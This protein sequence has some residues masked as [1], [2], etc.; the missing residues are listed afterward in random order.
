MKKI[1]LF[2]SLFVSILSA[3]AFADTAPVPTSE[4][5]PRHEGWSFSDFRAIPIQS[6]G[7]IKPLDSFAREAALFATGRRQFEGFDPADLLI[8]WIAFPR[9]WEN[10]RFVKI[11]RIDVRRE[12]QLDESR[13][14]FSP[15]E[16][17]NNFALLQYARNMDA[18]AAGSETMSG[19][20]DRGRK[21][22]PREQE[23]GNVLSRLTLFRD[24]VAGNAWLVIPHADGPWVSLAGGGASAQPPAPAEDE[25]IRAHF[26]DLIKAYQAGDMAAFDRASSVARAAVESRVPDW[27]GHM[28]RSL[29]LE[30]FYNR[31]HPFQFAWILYLAGALMWLVSPG[32]LLRLS[33]EQAS[34]ARVRRVLAGTLTSLAVIC[35]V[36]GFLIRCYIAGRPPVTNMYE[37]II[38]V[39]FGVF[40]FAFI[41]YLI[42]RLSITLIVAS[43]L[44][45]V[46]LIAA[47][48]APAMMDPGLHP[49][50]PVL[51]DNFWLTIHVLTIT[52]G[53]SAFALTLGLANVTLWNFFMIDRAGADA[54]DAPVARARI[55][56]LNQLTYRAMQFGVVL[57]AA[58]TILG[59][60]WA[61]YSWGRFWGWD[62]KEVWALIA[63]LCYLAVLHGRMT[64]WIKPFAFA[65]WTVVAFSSVV[66]AWY[67]VNFVL[68]VGL[69][70]Y[71]FASGGTGYV[72]GG[73]GLQLAYVLVIALHHIWTSKMAMVAPKSAV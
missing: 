51:R 2:L 32:K 1:L 15:S 62:P 9:E 5:A 54:S 53:Y 73:V 38:W 20:S 4:M 52:L 49:L 64:S 12:L 41:L 14:Y 42:Q 70:S 19:K 8:S 31:M 48:S 21:E 25:A 17:F 72:V 3:S 66:M 65:V 58:G 28:A 39:S 34:S 6:G 46:G 35:H 67:G 43:A 50:V 55:Q 45:T 40:A 27:D 71:G 18:S 44:S 10:H 36:G 63:L 30:V 11:S 60:V 61:D 68:G 56:T 7:R 59:G 23:L 22:S 37:S 24:I 26:V 69:H 29:G 47:D 57:L 13:V 16:L 33:K